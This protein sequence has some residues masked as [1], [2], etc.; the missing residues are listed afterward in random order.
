MFNRSAYNRPHVLSSSVIGTPAFD[1]HLSATDMESL[2][3][4]VTFALEAPARK[5]DQLEVSDVKGIHFEPRLSFIKMMLRKVKDV[6]VL[7]D[8]QTF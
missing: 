4:N 2:K 1:Y 6:C 8:T 7:S 3:T 5:L